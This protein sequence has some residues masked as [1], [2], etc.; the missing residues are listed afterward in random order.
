MATYL[1]IWPTRSVLL[2]EW[3]KRGVGMMD[4]STN[5]M[6]RKAWERPT[7]YRLDAADAQKTTAGKL[8]DGMNNKS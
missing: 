4:D 3:A 2:P 1:F 6:Q 5:P 8:N 7:L